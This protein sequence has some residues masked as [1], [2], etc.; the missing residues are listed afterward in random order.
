MTRL[1]ATV[2]IRP[3][4]TIPS[5]PPAE[6]PAAPQQILVAGPHL[7]VVVDLLLAA[8]LLRAAADLLRVAVPHLRVAVALLPAVA[9]Q[10]ALLARNRLP[11]L[12]ICP[13]VRQTPQV[14]MIRITAAQKI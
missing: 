12:S 3:L 13:L 9:L 1:S 8:D 5:S 7:R 6:L 14:M 11:A 2:E 10:L 4:Q